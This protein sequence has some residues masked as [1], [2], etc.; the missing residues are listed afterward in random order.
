MAKKLKKKIKVGILGGTFD[1]PHFGHISSHNLRC[2]SHWNQGIVKSIRIF[3]KQGIT[4]N[5]LVFGL[6]L[7][8]RR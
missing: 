5:K 8:S 6:P 7:Y 2:Y 1:P 4:L 3:S